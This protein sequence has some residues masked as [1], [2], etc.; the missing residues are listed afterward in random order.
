MSEKRGKFVTY[1]DACNRIR[2]GS[3]T[4]FKSDYIATFEPFHS[5][6]IM[7]KRILTSQSQIC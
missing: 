2:K 6:E 3:S 1:I 4:D 7:E 5:D